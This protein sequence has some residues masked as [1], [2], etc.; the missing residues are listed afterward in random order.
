M[1]FPEVHPYVFLDKP[2]FALC[3]CCEDWG[4]TFSRFL[5]A[6]GITED[7]WGRHWSAER[8]YEYSEPLIFPRFN[9]ICV[10]TLLAFFSSVVQRIFKI[11]KI[12]LFFV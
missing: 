8:P 11:T 1:D 9:K 10:V 3:F 4:T 5:G 12:Q 6:S 7:P 2:F